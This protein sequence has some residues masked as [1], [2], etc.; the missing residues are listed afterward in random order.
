MKPA[1][2]V[3]SDTFFFARNLRFIVS[4]INVWDACKYVYST[5]RKTLMS[6]HLIAFKPTVTI[7][8]CSMTA[9]Y[10]A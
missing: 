2:H 4:N 7:I 9:I 8:A 5:R 10:N 1:Q 6:G 3:E